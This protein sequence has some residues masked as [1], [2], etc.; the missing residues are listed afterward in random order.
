MSDK[1]DDIPQHSHSS[2]DIRTITAPILTLLSI[3]GMI[4]WATTSV[5]EQKEALKNEVRVEIKEINQEYK[6]HLDM[7]NGTLRQYQELISQMEDVLLIMKYRQKFL[8]EN[9]WSKRDHAIWC[10]EM[11]RISE[12]FKCPDEDL[13]RSGLIGSDSYIGPIDR[14]RKQMLEDIEKEGN[15]LFNEKYYRHSPNYYNKKKE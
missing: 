12:Q 3:A 1:D 13:K 7:V 10:R 15:T 6:E 5:W 14:D 8:L 9:M 11:E 4:V 2:V